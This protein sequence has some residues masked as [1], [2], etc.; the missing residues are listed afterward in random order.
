MIPAAQFSLF[1]LDTGR[2]LLRDF[3]QDDWL[4][5]FALSQEP[6]VTEFQSWLRLTDEEAAWRWVAEAIFH[7]ALEPRH[8]Y[9]L[10]V[11]LKE[12]GQ[13]IGW[14]GWGKPSRPEL[15]DYAFG[16]ALLPAFW[17]RGLMSEALRAAVDFMFRRQ[18]AEIVFGKCDK[19]NPASARVMEKAGLRLAQEWSDVD[20]ESGGT[21]T[22]QRYAA[23][24]SEFLAGE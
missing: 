18:K 8:S 22:M 6:G 13:V 16:Y 3:V 24:R 7:N 19:I 17:G 4:A 11:T 12:S 23:T 14:L 20:E 10:A 5:V 15:G 1:C 2:L 21:V 9:N